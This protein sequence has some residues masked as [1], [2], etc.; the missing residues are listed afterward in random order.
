MWGIGGVIFYSGDVYG[1]VTA[2]IGERLVET[3]LLGEDV[4]TV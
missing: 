4:L 1:H 3:S 2:M